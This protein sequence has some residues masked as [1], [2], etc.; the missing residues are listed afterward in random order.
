[1]QAQRNTYRR[2]PSRQRKGR[3]VPVKICSTMQS[4]GYSLLGAKASWKNMHTMLKSTSAARRM[5]F[6]FFDSYKSHSKITP[7]GN[8]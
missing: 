5:V 7:N 3:S 2:Y 1:M 8:K 6:T 4:H